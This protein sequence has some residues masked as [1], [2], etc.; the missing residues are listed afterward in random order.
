MSGLQVRCTGVLFLAVSLAGCATCPRNECKTSGSSA[1]SI[2]VEPYG[3]APDGQD[4]S[5]YTLTNANGMEAKITNFGGIVQSLKTP[6]RDGDLADI[7]LGHD[8]LP[9]YVGK[10]PYFGAIVG[11]YG[12]RIAKGKFSLD[13]KEYTL[14]VN[15]GPNALHGGLKGFDKQV[16][17]AAPIEE[18]GVAGL[19]LRYVSPDGEEGYPGALTVTVT[20]LLTNDNALEIRYEATADAPTVLNLTNHSYFNLDGAGTGDILDHEVMINADRFT[21]VDGTLIPTGE[22]RPVKGTPFDFRSPKPIGR[23][24]GAGDEQIKFGGGYDHNFVLNKDAQDA[25][26]LAAQVYAPESGRLMEVYTEEPGMQFYTGNFLDST[27]V[28][29]G[30]IPYAYRNGFCMETQH[31]PDSPNQPNFPSVVLRPGEKYETTTIYK[32]L[33]K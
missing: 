24:I 28:G 11:R 12:N 19:K 5:L 21:P 22:L 29:K 13:G 33:A 10:H 25:L 26:T 23:D 3:T 16:W 27:D 6:D 18:A 14:A 20:Y 8:A 30:G 31:Y 7:V 17:T 4:V 9:G 1:M 32:F 15:D 2:S